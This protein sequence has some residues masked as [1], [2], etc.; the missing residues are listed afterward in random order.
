MH[1]TLDLKGTSLVVRLEEPGSRRIPYLDS[2]NRL[3]KADELLI[4]IHLR[5][6]S[7]S[8]L[9]TLSFQ[10]IILPSHCADVIRAMIQTKHLYFR[11]KKIEESLKA[12]LYWKGELHSERSGTFQ[13]MINQTP[14]ESIDLLVPSWAIKG[15]QWMEIET[16]VAWKWVERFKLG[17]AL[18]EGVQMKHFLEEKPLVL[19]KKIE[20][21]EVEDALEHIQVKSVVAPLKPDPVLVLTD[22]TG[23]FVNLS[24]Q[25]LG[26][27][28]ISFEDL[29][30]SVGGK[31][32][33]KNEEVQLEK[34]LL[35]AGY[36]RKVVGRS[37]YYCP[38]ELARQVLQF[39]LE[40]GW[41]CFDS[42]GRKIF[43][44]TG[45]DLHV[46]EHADRIR[47]KGC[48]HFQEKV[49]SLQAA[50][51]GRLL[52][53][54]DSQ[55][56]G[57][58]DADAIPLLDGDWDDEGM[59][60]PK[61]RL[62]ELLPLLEIPQVQWESSL[63]KAAMSFQLG[64]G[65]DPI[66]LSSFQGTLLPYQEKGVE[67]LSFLKKW[68][69]SALLSDEMGL[70]KTVQVLAFFSSLRTNLPILIVAPTSLIFNWKREAAKFWP[71]ATVYIHSGPNRR[72]DL[73][74]QSIVLTSYAL[75]RIDQELFSSLE[76]EAIALDESQMI[77]SYT[78]Q[79]AKAAFQLN[80]RF[81]IAITGTPVENRSEE[82]WSQFRYLMPELLGAKSEFQ[83]LE[84]EAIRRK[85]KP[86]VLR[87]RKADVQIDLPEKIDQPVWVAMTEEQQ[88][89]YE[90][91]LSSF[92]GGLLKQ[93]QSDGLQ[94][95][96]MEVLEVI[97]RLRQICCDPRL[98]GG[99]APG[100]KAE[101]VKLMA[102]EL[103]KEGKKGLIF[104]Q[105][106]SFL[107]ILQ[108]D[109]RQVGIEPL[110]LDGSTTAEERGELVQRF[111]EEQKPHL[112]LLSLKA[113]GVGLNLTA[114]E[115]VIL[116]DPWW[117]EAVE[118]QAIDR[119][120]RIGQKNTLFVS[121]FLTP[122]AIEEKMLSIKARKSTIAD[123]LIAEEMSGWASTDL[124]DL[125]TLN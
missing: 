46:S 44:Q 120:H 41:T 121:R 56:V 101:L 22:A 49:V 26:G 119:A 102:E 67:W 47:V 1:Y 43:L 55:S 95:H 68:G 60:V 17:P 106:T 75:L 58:L 48:V 2:L 52:Q 28:T 42:Q 57:L 13:A 115:S 63:K 33:I 80:G 31:T 117:N 122:E 109:L 73:Q 89:L 74:G 82:L 107:R 86:F 32:R 81:K 124:L 71:T 83:Q 59:H 4:K 96:R 62:G 36:S 40:V 97:L 50:Q 19:Y 69:F 103:V 10:E 29:A 90:Q 65:F 76:F 3:I 61:R 6:H 18:L 64:D 12:K 20:I 38:S 98:K 88:A 108:K 23:C 35:E 5:S 70:G 93:V 111:Q 125:L 112:F 37:R 99:L 14:L 91:T 9:D 72:K 51:N 78:S 53:P 84:A 25:Y 77:K 66:C 16:E 113:G 8:S 15:N 114:A 85:I 116:L 79:V 118:R 11:G 34:D 104:S 39:L 21:V 7:G 105:F 92:K 45:V 24:M 110:Y 87:R 54:I 94:A 100:G 123:Q 27:G 30:P